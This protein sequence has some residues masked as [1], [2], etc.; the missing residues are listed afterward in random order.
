MNSNLK[1]FFSN[2]LTLF[3]RNNLNIRPLGYC[4]M[5]KNVLS[6][7]DF[8]F[9]ITKNNFDT[10][11]NVTNLASQVLPNINQKCNVIF[12][13][14][15]HLGNEI[16]RK[17][18]ILDYFGISFVVSDYFENSF[19]SMAIFHNFKNFD[20]LKNRV[21]LLQKKAD[22]AQLSRWTLELCPWK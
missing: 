14:F 2:N 6:V 9:W 17:E 21:L 1:N 12:V 5:K 13:F 4:Y 8:F 22:R 20:E 18:K 15:D 16:K 7:S 19:G 10:K 3:F 11:I